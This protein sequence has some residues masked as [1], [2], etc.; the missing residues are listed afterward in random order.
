MDMTM[1]MSMAMNIGGMS[2]PMNM[3]P[4]KMTADCAVTGVA[5][6]GDITYDIA[7]TEFAMDPSA[8][9]NPTIAA[10]MQ[11]LQ[12]SITSIKGTATISNRGV[13]R[14]AKLDVADAQLKQTI[15]QMTSQI[16]NLSM[17]MPEEAVGVGARWEVRLA[18][19]SGGPTMF[20]KTVYEV[21]SIDGSSVSLKVTTEQTA[22][23]QP[24]SNP[25]MPAGSEIYMDKMTGTGSGTATIKLDSLVPTSEVTVTSSMSMTVSMGGQSQA[26]TSDNTL[27]MT[28]GPRK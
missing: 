12:A 22:P 5:P 10:A 14:S 17:P 28:I 25:A 1:N 21:V 27:K 4:M 19:V 13:T 8:D 6:N 24:I 2:M 15:G 23:A 18:M 9:A 7:F 20:Q 11:G 16:E 26:M 3:P